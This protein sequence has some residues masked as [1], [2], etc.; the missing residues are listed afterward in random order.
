MKIHKA[1]IK[2]ATKIH[3]LINDSAKANHVLPRA[4]SYIY[5]NIRDFWIFI[6]DDGDVI[7]CVALHIIWEDLAEIKS[8]V[9]RKDFQSKGLGGE[10]I[11]KALDEAKD[12]ELKKVFVLTYIPEYF[13]L[14]GFKAIDKN[15]LPHKIWVECIN[16]PKFPGCE[17]EAMIKEL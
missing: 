17:E 15:E 7:A 9:V 13:S 5:E 16:C 11:G 14:F 3:D 8:L 6:Q 10:L 4:L 1:K 12:Y 2:E